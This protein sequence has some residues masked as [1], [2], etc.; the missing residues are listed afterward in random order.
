MK[1]QLITLAVGALLWSVPALAQPDPGNAPKG[2]NPAA[3]A[4]PGGFDWGNMTPQQRRLAVQGMVEQTLRGSM[5]HLGY[6]DAAL[7]DAVVAAALEQGKILEPVR[8][9]HRRLAQALIGNVSDRDAAVLLAQWRA[10]VEE[11]ERGRRAAATALDEK[12]DFSR[13]PKLEA[14]LRSAGLVGDETNLMGGVAGGLLGT[15][16]NL[17]LAPE[18][19]AAPA[20]AAAQRDTPLDAYITRAEPLY[21]R[22]KVAVVAEATPPQIADNPLVAI[23]AGGV[24]VHELRLTSQQWQG[25][26]WQHRVQV[27]RP[28]KMEFPR[29]ALLYVTGGGG[30]ALET[31][32]GRAL[33]NATGATVVSLFNIPNQPLYNG[34]YED[35]L[36]A[37]T[38]QQYLETG[39]ATWPL[40]FPMTKS[41]VKAMDAVAEYSREQGWPEL[42]KFVVTGASKRGWTTWLTGAVDK[43]V[44]GI[45]PMVYDNLNLQAQMPHQL[46]TWGEYSE[47]IKDYTRLGLQEKMATERGGKMAAMVDPYTYRERLTMPK[48]IVN[49]TNDRYWALDALNFYVNDLPGPTNVLYFPN[50]GHGLGDQVPMLITSLS[51]WFRQVAAEKPLPRVEL[52]KIAPQDGERRFTLTSRTELAAARLWVATSATRDF[53]EA[54]WNAQAMTKRADGIWTASLPTSPAQHTAVFAEARLPGDEGAAPGQMPLRVSSPIELFAPTE[55]ETQ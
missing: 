2:G 41:A 55:K 26:V 49:G 33:A 44:I 23:L 32:V 42:D 39:D 10:T 22:E 27:F 48:L 46:E 54:K 52:L 40:L 53:R 29:T 15:M 35:A 8:D 17:A 6:R 28:A 4:Q 37:H 51:A 19:D 7:Q 5:S 12:I 24:E 25:H 47:Q 21:K 34:K 16:T 36:I 43:R 20:L 31:M 38:F 18:P 11:A 1:K 45:M 9:K 13:K 14:L 3:A 30:S 50:A